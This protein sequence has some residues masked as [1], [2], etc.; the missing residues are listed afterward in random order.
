[1]ETIT[2]VEI[3]HSSRSSYEKKRVNTKKGI[4]S[5]K[6]EKVRGSGSHFIQTGKIMTQSKMSSPLKQICKDLHM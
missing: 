2:A 5:K 6:M 1:M 4:V 3:I